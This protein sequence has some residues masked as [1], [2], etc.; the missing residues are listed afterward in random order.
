MRNKNL[1]N[2]NL[3]FLDL[4]SIASFVIGIEN[5]EENITQGD[6][7]E[8]MED[9]NKQIQKVLDEVHAHLESQDKKLDEILR[10]LK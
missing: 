6:K 1:L 4:I 9:L 8:M 3:D 5:L 7:Q 10:R 2:N